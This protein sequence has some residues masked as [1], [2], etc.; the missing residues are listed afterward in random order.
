MVQ[1]KVNAT[2]VKDVLHGDDCTEMRF[3]INCLVKGKLE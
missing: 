3:S 1:V 2:F